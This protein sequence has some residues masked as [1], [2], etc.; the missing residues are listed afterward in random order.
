MLNIKFQIN[1]LSTLIISFALLLGFILPEEA[2][3]QTYHKRIEK[4]RG[5]QKNADVKKEEEKP[6]M[7][8]YQVGDT[9][10]FFSETDSPLSQDGSSEWDEWNEYYDEW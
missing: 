3:S 10:S 4:A 2:Y 6:V 1:Y 8:K 9:S 7:V 5:N